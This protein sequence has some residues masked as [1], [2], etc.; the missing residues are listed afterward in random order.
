MFEELILQDF[1]LVKKV[2]LQFHQAM[3]VVSGETGAGKSSIIKAIELLFGG[4]AR[5]N[6][7]R[8]GAQKANITALLCYPQ[9]TKMKSF[10][11]EQDL[12]WSDGSIIIRR[13]LY[14]DGKSKAFVNDQLV[15]LSTLT[16][17]ASYVVELQGTA[18][19]ANFITSGQAPCFA[20]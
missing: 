1:I 18:R 13:T 3:Q 16:Q 19:A 7:V 9:H 4:R 5:N 20:R 11:E 14:Q 15:G 8:H 6:F 12:P 10:F 17:I 2:H